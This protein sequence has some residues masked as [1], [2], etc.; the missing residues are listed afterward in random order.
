MEAADLKFED[1]KFTEDELEQAII[2]LFQQQDADG[3]RWS[4][5][6]GEQLHRRY[7][8]LLYTSDAAD[9]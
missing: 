3:V 7:D 8:C 4:Y 1:G 6:N 2:E 5:A 9:E